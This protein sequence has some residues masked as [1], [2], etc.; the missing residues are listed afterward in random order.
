MKDIRNKM[1]EITISDDR[2]T[3]WVNTD[4]GCQFRAEKIPELKIVDNSIK[5]ELG[6]F[7]N[8][9]PRA[10]YMV[11]MG[12]CCGIGLILFLDLEGL[13]P[14]VAAVGMIIGVTIGALIGY[15]IGRRIEKKELSR[16]G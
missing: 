5:E 10:M 8:I 2:Q 9:S 4:E 7:I 12:V 6:E 16:N 1:V 14:A 3:V 15:F 13:S 11:G